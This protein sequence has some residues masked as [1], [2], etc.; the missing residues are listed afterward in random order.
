MS[1][2]GFLKEGA[3]GQHCS[4]SVVSDMVANLR[5]AP[6]DALLNAIDS[7]VH[8]VALFDASDRLAYSNEAFRKGWSVSAQPGATFDTIMRHCFKSKTGAIIDTDDLETWLAEARHKRRSGASDRSFEVDLW[9]GRWMWLTERRLETG[10]VFF[11]AQDITALKKSERTLRLAR[12]AAILA[13][14]TD[15]LTGLANRR[16]A[17]QFIE[18]C[19]KRNAAFHVGVADVDH[20]KLINDRF[21]HQA[22][23]DALV[24]LG[25]ELRSLERHGYFVARLAGDEFVII[26]PLNVTDVDLD[27]GLRRFLKRR[28]DHSS[29]CEASKVFGISVG[30]ARFPSDGNTVKELL[31]AA[32]EAMYR[33]KSQGRCNLEFAS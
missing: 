24:Q 20:F 6:A 9:D 3:D 2:A 11:L 22:G 1:A 21:G 31:K 13:S 17:M 18:E 28:V 29:A 5:R 4:S 14:M 30:A 12:D 33:A 27:A 19:I 16:A 25:T 10:W 23:D 8:A 26:S 15:P 7:G 32:D